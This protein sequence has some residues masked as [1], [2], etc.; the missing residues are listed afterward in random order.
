MSGICGLFNQNKIP[1]Q[2]GDLGR[3]AS[4]LGRRG[5][6]RTGNWSD[7]FIGMGHTLL[8][9]T[10]EARN[11]HLPLVHPGSSC[12]ITADARIDNRSELIKSLDGELSSTPAG[13][14]EIILAAYLAWDIACVDHLL[15]DFAFAIWDPRRHRL[16]CARD[17]LGIRPFYYHQAGHFFTFASEP[18]AL[19]TLPQVPYRI[20]EGRIADFLITQ[21]EGID[22]TS[23]FFEEVYRLPPAHTLI[24]TPDS[25]QKQRYWRLE[26]APELKLSSDEEYAEAFREV[27]TEAV[28][29]R[30]R[31]VD[32]TGSMLSG[33]MDSGSI[34]ALASEIMTGEGWG[35]LPTFSAIAPDPETC[36]ETRTIQAAL[37][38]EGLQPHIIDYGQLD[39]FQSKLQ[40]LVRNVDEPFDGHMTIVQAIYLS[41]RS[42]AIKALL[43]GIDGDTVLSEGSHLVR[44]LRQG[45]WLTAC[46]EAVGQNRFWGGA[47]PA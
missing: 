42:H 2:N 16:F 37:T 30:L 46:R 26:P 12:V 8:A 5:P 32:T 41:A 25:M 22:K 3:M 10:P 6:D 36:I 18:R 44:L 47:Y 33:G 7:G 29:C 20:N 43:D 27:L 39:A 23:T 14:A 17:H 21:L 11:E 31:G 1:V 34:V 13:D 40:D 45:S 19:L 24:V 9:S 28:H 38:I 4:L 15:G 35:P